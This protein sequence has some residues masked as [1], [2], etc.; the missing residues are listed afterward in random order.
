MPAVCIEPRLQRLQRVERRELGDPGVAELRHVGR[1]VAGE[2]GQQLLVGGAPRQ[3]LDAHVESRMLAR[4]I[5]AA[6]R[7]PPRPRA[8]SPRSAACVH[9]AALQPASASAHAPATPAQQAAARPVADRHGRDGAAAR[10]QSSSSQ[11]PVKPARCSPRRRCTQLAHR[12][13]H[14]A[15]CGEVRDHRQDRALVDAEVVGVD[16]ADAGHDAPCGSGVVEVK[17]GLKESTKPYL[18]VDVLAVAA[19][20]SPDG[21]DHDLGRERQRSTTRPRSARS[22]R[23]RSMRAAAARA[24][25]VVARRSAAAVPGTARSCRPGRRTR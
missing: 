23:R 18:P 21:R 9:R 8:P 5:G 3:L 13:P 7:P 10:H 16:P 11:P 20:A 22:C 4:E 25:A 6:A 17:L 14:R 24:A 12:L 19:H 15:R 2:R 1:G